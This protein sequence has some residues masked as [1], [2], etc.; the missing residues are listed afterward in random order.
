[1]LKSDLDYPDDV[2]YRCSS[3]NAELRHF[4]VGLDNAKDMGYGVDLTMLRIECRLCEKEV[5]V[6]AKDFDTGILSRLIVRR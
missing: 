4:R 5:A 3:C 6:P 2:K 1:M